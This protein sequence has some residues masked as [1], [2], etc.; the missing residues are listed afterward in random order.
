MIDKN[1][2]LPLYQQVKKSILS[3]IKNGQYTPGDKL[4]S[5]KKLIEKYNVSRNTIRNALK[6]LA[7][8][9]WIEIV[10]G[11]GSYIS[12]QKINLNFVTWFSGDE[13]LNLIK[14]KFEKKVPICN[15][16]IIQI[17]FD[18]IKNKLT[19]MISSGIAPDIIHMRSNWIPFFAKKSALEPLDNIINSGKLNERDREFDINLGSVNNILYGIAWLIAPMVLFTNQCVLEK[20]DFKKQVPKNIDELEKLSEKINLHTKAKGLSIPIENKEFT[21]YYLTLMIKLYG[22]RLWDDNNKVAI[23]SDETIMAFQQLKRKIDNGLFTLNKN[24][25]TISKSF[26]RNKIGFM[27][28]V[29]PGL[30]RLKNWSKKDKYLKLSCVPQG[31]NDFSNSWVSNQS[32]C[33]SKQSKNKQLAGKFIEFVT[34]NNSVIKKLHKIEGV[35]PPL[36]R[37][38]KLDEFK[39]DPYIKVFNKQ[40]QKS[41]NMK[42]TGE[43]LTLV[44]YFFNIAAKNI[45]VDNSPIEEELKEKSEIIRNLLKDKVTVDFNH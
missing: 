5:E 39:N 10:H 20:I 38:L 17:P 37:H 34:E 23:D 31:K 26:S 45:L 18:D 40:L 27:F 21:G 44:M 6:A 2:P 12:S 41:S 24:I 42:P 9:G 33:I 25:N 28:D 43:L 35:Y 7:D 30:G 19:E 22:G 11:K 32:L 1:N 36:K 16:N 29:P 14:D 4:M 8:E 15:L 13:I 3:K